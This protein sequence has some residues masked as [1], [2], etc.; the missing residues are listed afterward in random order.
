MKVLNLSSP[1]A[2]INST[3]R[4]STKDLATHKSN[5]CQICQNIIKFDIPF[6]TIPS[7]ILFAWLAINAIEE[8]DTEKYMQMTSL[9]SNV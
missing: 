9:E 6:S 7:T 8:K 5:R 1:L 3:E 2:S 4:I